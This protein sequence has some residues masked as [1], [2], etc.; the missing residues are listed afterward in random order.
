MNTAARE[1]KIIKPI[2]LKDNT[3]KVR[4]AAY[5]RVSTNSADQVNSFFAQMKY[6]NDYIY[7]NS[8][9][10]LVDIYADEGIT[11]TSIERRD[12]FK[13][14]IKD[15]KNRKIDRVLVKSV[16]R[17]ARN[18]LECI[19]TIRQLK[20][21]G[22]SVFFENDNIDT[23]RMDSEMLLYI[24]S[25][26]AQGEALSASKRMATSVRMRM[27]NGT[28]K[29]PNVPYGYKMGEFELIIVPDQAEKVK[30]IFRIYLSGRGIN[31]IAKYMN[32]KYGDKE[33]WGKEI[34]RY[35]LTNEKYI[36]D[37]L[38][39]KTFTPAELP[40]Q[41]RPNRGEM[42]KYYSEGTHEAIISKEDFKA[43]QSLLRVRERKH[44]KKSDK[45]TRSLFFYQKIRCRKCGRVYK[46][47]KC[48][49]G[50][51]WICSKKGMTMEVCSSAIYAEDEIRKAFV[52]MYNILRQN[53]RIVLDETI[54]QL[55]ALKTKVNNGNNAITEIDEELASLG[56][57]NN[58]YNNL[59]VEKMI[60]EIIYLEKTDKI[61]GQMTELRNKRLMLINEDEDERCIDDLRQIKKVLAESP[62]YLTQMDE[63]LFS[64]IVEILYGEENGDLTFVLKGGLELR[65]KTR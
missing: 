25:A 39:Q 42:P 53:Q 58:I 46:Q 38:N 28:Y 50:I 29:L 54:S 32:I 35:I 15:C 20:S 45:E 49:D 65:V 52:K 18:S 60:D 13:R 55:L 64:R 1:V 57:Q 30:E 44:F 41:S 10:V 34:I 22:T 12:E 31:A 2:Q 62:E 61:K 16:T 33:N 37:C 4:V 3:K 56:E 27:E 47:R 43:V 24:K 6:Y 36:G 11:G 59:Y 14:L 19:E 5:C 7:H 51:S 23:E 63:L 26:F 8:D 40:L 17:F 48:A 9:M 21:Y